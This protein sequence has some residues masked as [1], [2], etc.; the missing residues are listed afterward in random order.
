VGFRS[1]SARRR[2][3]N[4]IPRT[5]EVHCPAI[6]TRLR[7]QVP[8]FDAAG[9]EGYKVFTHDHVVE[10]C[11][12]ALKDSPSWDY[13]IEEPI[14]QGAH[15]ELCWRRGSMLDWIRWETNV[16]GD[17][18]AWSVLYGLCLGKVRSLQIGVS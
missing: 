1:V 18:R 4:E 6:E 2:L 3:G 8:E 10:V 11:R 16:D 7:L 17:N 5:F 9:G 15:L 13:L 14:R 12:E